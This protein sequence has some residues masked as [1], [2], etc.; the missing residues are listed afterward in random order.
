MYDDGNSERKI[1]VDLK[2]SRAKNLIPNFI[3]I[4]SG[5]CDTNGYNNLISLHECSQ[6]TGGTVRSLHGQVDIYGCAEGTTWNDF[7]SH[8]NSS[9]I[10]DKSWIDAMW[11]KE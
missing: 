1:V 7:N 3:S 2:I 4:T 10:E 11:C 8:P 9:T 5:N 6:A